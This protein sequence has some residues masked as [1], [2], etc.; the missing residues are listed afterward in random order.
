MKEVQ[1]KAKHSI[2][3]DIFSKV[4]YDINSKKYML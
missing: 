1:G 4:S 3:I 2:T